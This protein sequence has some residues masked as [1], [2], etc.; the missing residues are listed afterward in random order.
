MNF[1]HDPYTVRE[2]IEVAKK[3]K[4]PNFYQNENILSN[5]IN[6]REIAF[7]KADGKTFLRIVDIEQY[8]DF[9]LL[10]GGVL[11]LD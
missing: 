11:E 2:L 9:S 3:N 5:L 8:I 1:K 4:L 7:I 6:N 10:M